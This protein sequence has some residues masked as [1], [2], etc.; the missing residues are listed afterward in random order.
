MSLL[1]QPAKP[2]RSTCQPLWPFSPNPW[3]LTAALRPSRAH[4]SAPV[5]PR[6]G[7][8]PTSR[9]VHA[10]W[11]CCLTHRSAWFLAP[12][13]LSRVPLIADRPL[14]TV[15]QLARATVLRP[16]R[17]DKRHP[18][19]LCSNRLGLPEHSPD[20]PNHRSPACALARPL[21][22]RAGAS[23]HARVP[24]PLQPDGSAPLATRL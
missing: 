22:T 8:R 16:P 19:K 15:P 14:P 4:T 23:P 7:H 24:T 18:S 11:P 17:S 6:Q 20:L 13:L 5:T 9:P 1:P 3:C 10:H 12:L 2:P 21:A